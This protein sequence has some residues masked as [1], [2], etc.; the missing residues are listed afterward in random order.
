MKSVLSLLPLVAAV[1][2]FNEQC[3][4]VTVTETVYAS[5]SSIKPAPTTLG[6][7]TK[8]YTHQTPVSTY[9]KPSSSSVGFPTGT[10]SSIAYA[11]LPASSSEPISP[12]TYIVASAP[13]SDYAAIP[14]SGIPVAPSPSSEVPVQSMPAPIPTSEEPALPAPSNTPVQEESNA[15]LEVSKQA[16]SGKATFYGGNLS[17]GTCSFTGYTLPSGTFG[18][19][20]SGSA[21]NSAANCGRCVNVKGPNGKTIKAMV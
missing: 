2:A 4:L 17:G 1:A 3:S 5:P 10:I 14:S 13:S 6:T 7:S 11:V 12:S 9:T 19:A 15:N 8:D 18:T 21:W 20:F 16:T